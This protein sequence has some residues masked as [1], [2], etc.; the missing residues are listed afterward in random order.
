MNA[1]KN[2]NLTLLQSSRVAAF[3]L[4]S[5]TVEM[6]YQ[7]ALRR[8]LENGDQL[9]IAHAAVKDKVDIVDEN[10]NAILTESVDSYPGIFEEIWVSVDDY[11]SDSI[12]GLVITIHLPEE[13]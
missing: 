5:I 13:H 1:P 10:G 8:F 6:L 4:P 2:R 9:L 12:E 3:E 11:G 7:T